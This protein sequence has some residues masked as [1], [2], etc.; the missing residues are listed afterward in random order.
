[1]FNRPGENWSPPDVLRATKV[2]KKAEFFANGT[3]DSTQIVQGSI[4]DCWFLSALS[5]V[6]T[7]P[8]LLEQL[9]VAVRSYLHHRLTPPLK[10]R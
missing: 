5:S 3:P 6:A 2:F 1:M 8:G 7:A 10:H 9:C 4:G